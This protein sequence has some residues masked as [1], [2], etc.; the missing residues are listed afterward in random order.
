MNRIKA[1]ASVVLGVASSP[2][3][4]AESQGYL[5]VGYLQLSGEVSAF[6]TATDTDFSVATMQVGV[7][8][9]KHLAIEVMLGTGI[10][11]DPIVVPEVGSIETDLNAVY[12]LVLKP[13]VAISDRVS[14]YGELG[15]V[16]YEVE[17][18]LPAELASSLAGTAEFDDGMFGAGIQV[19]LGEQSY[20]ELGY[21]AFGDS[22]DGVMLSVGVAF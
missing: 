10:D 7:Q 9:H 4:A 5:E 17:Y 1:I 20:A 3:L 15:Y 16:W 8:L 13:S 22:V 18:A 19:D 6:D 11:G 12:G 21:A 2:L 14:L